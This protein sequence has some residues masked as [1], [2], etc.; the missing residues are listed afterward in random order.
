M[1]TF[2]DYDF[3]INEISNTLIVINER[4]RAFVPAKEVRNSEM[5]SHIY[6]VRGMM[7]DVKILFEL[8]R[9]AKLTPERIV[10]SEFFTFINKLGKP[11]MI[12]Y[13]TRAIQDFDIFIASA[14]QK[15]Y[16]YYTDERVVEKVI[17]RPP[18]CKVCHLEARAFDDEFCHLHTLKSFKYTGPIH[19]DD[20]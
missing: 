13:L 3:A 5:T 9:D 18:M 12:L 1:L 20:A 19:N 10:T 4:V 6:E 7:E 15:V 14:I 2:E 17:P 11:K 16:E 8:A